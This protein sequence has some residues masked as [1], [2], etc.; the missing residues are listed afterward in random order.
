MLEPAIGTK[1]SLLPN[2][3]VFTVTHSGLSVPS[4]TNTLLTLPIFVPSEDTTVRSKYSLTLLMSYSLVSWS[5]PTRRP[6]RSGPLRRSRR[7]HLPVD[8]TAPSR[9]AER[10]ARVIDQETATADRHTY[11]LKPLP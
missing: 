7:G 4:S 11:V 9:V 3:P 10:S 8:R 6:P 2:I 1:D 5:A